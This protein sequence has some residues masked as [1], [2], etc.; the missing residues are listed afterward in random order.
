MRLHA[1]LQLQLSWRVGVFAKHEG[2]SWV[3][4]GYHAFLAMNPSI[5]CGS[6]I[7]DT[8]HAIVH[9]ICPAMGR[10][11]LI[12]L[13]TATVLT[14]GV[15]EGDRV[16]VKLVHGAPSNPTPTASSARTPPA[17]HRQPKSTSG[18]DAFRSLQGTCFSIDLDAYSYH[19]CPFANVT[20][21]QISSSWT[22]FWGILGIWDE[23]NSINNTY[24]TMS[25]TDGTDCGS[26]R[27]QAAVEFMCSGPGGGYA[28]KSVSEPK[29]CE[30]HLLLAC[31]QAC[32]ADY[33]MGHETEIVATS[34]PASPSVSLSASASPLA[35]ASAAMALPSG[36]G[37]VTPTPSSPPA[38]IDGHSRARS[39][40]A[41]ASADQPSRSPTPSA[42]ALRDAKIE[43]VSVAASAATSSAAIGASTTQ[44]NAGSSSTSSSDNAT[45][46]KSSSTAAAILDL[47]AASAGA[48]GCSAKIADLKR[49]VD[50]LQ[51][52][53]N[54]L[55]TSCSL[56]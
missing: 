54:D 31:P 44:D 26:K 49:Q 38:V 18:P 45:G 7:L 29:T 27:R 55:A 46:S 23:W 3:T 37:V 47:T 43:A 39:A 30:Y 51:S 25:Y 12:R 22:S 36:F 6:Q 52:A 28:I 50:M 33:V 53:V 9:R 21:K 4:R 40:A 56:Q 8:F 16:A 13:L 32:E 15:T 35:T 19:V 48:L 34:T 41:A 20:Q 10:F 17:A 2:S 14:F 5:I 42:D 1:T 11:P 24:T